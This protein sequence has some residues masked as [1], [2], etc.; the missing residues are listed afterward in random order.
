MAAS[1]KSVGRKL[2]VITVVLLVLAVGYL[3]YRIDFADSKQAPVASEPQV[4]ETRSAA[5]PDQSPVPVPEAAIA[6]TRRNEIVAPRIAPAPVSAVTLPA[7]RTPPVKDSAIRSLA[8]D[9]GPASPD[10]TIRANNGADV[11]TLKIAAVAPEGSQWMR[12]MRASADTIREMTAGR[13]S[14]KYYGGGS[15]GSD[16]QALKR[17]R[18]GYLQGAVLTPSALL[19]I[20]PDLGI[21]G[22]PFLFRSEQ[23]ADYVRSRVDARLRSGLQQAGFV[24]FG[25]A[26]TGFTYLMSNKEISRLVDLDGLRFWV[27]ESDALSHASSLAFGV[28]PVPLPL[29]DLYT[30]LQVGI[31]DVVAISPIAAIVLQYHTKFRYLTD[32][33][34]NFTMALLA[35]D[36]KAFAKMPAADQQVVCTVMADLFAEYEAI[37]RADEIDAKTALFEAGILPTMVTM[38]EARKMRELAERSNRRLAQSGAFSAAL[39]EEILGYLDDY[40]SSM[41]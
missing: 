3:Y 13:V 40:R 18:I 19:E 25:F 16:S 21:Y 10:S 37:N 30:A 14:I 29:T 26:S 1:F 27:P 4:A 20:Y 17:I 36:A 41:K 39:Y 12:D 38:D 2:E 23:E 8:C 6:N 9:F 11:T 5:N 34:V 28:L 24:S 33:P 15:M 35:I 32:L 7:A 31:I 22:L